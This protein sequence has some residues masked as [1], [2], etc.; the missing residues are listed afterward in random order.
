MTKENQGER[1]HKFQAQLVKPFRANCQ[2]CGNRKQDAIHRKYIQ[3]EICHKEFS[4]NTFANHMK[5][6]HK[7]IEVLEK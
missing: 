4:I 7:A 5:K 6:Q 3:C 2:V 1:Q